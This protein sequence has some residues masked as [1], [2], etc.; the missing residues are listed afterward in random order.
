MKVQTQNPASYLNNEIIDSSLERAIEKRL[1]QLE[2][3]WDAERTLELNST[4]AELNGTLLGNLLINS[5]TTLPVVHSV[6]TTT[7][8]APT[9]EVFLSLGYRPKEKIEKEKYVLN[10]LKSQ[11]HVN[12]TFEHAKVA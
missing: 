1:V 10:A 3:E 12:N 2:N 4:L 7:T 9:Q 8:K 11:F 6:A 5:M